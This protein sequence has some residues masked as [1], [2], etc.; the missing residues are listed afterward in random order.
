[1]TESRFQRWADV[2]Q[3]F[4]HV[5]DPNVL[6]RIDNSPALRI[7]L[8]ISRPGNWWGLGVEP[9][10]LISIS[11]GEGIPLA[12][13]PRREI[14]SLLA[15]AEDDV[16]RSQVLLANEHDILEDCSAALG[17]CTDPW[18]ASTVLLALRAVDAHRSGFHE[19]GMALAVS[20]G[21]PLAAWG[22]EPRVRAF[23]SNQHRKAWEALVR[24]NSGYRRA[25]LELDE[26]RLDPHRR[27]V[28][29][30]A[31]AAPIPK[32]FTTWHRHQN[33]PPP[34]YLSRHVVAHQPSVQHFTRRNALVAL[35]LVSSLLRAQQD[36]SEDVRASDAVDEEPE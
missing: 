5:D 17:E 3:E 13:V 34:D 15:R 20:L 23:D 26:A 19:A 33:V 4:Q 2:E 6:Q 8:E 29:W 16:E 10:T 1:M 12:W 35:M 32:F 11:R 22:A 36:W 31:L 9:G 28:I 18:L 25:E 24:K 21:E 30:Q 14:I 7:A 27:D